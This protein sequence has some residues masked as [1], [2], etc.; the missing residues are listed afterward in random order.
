MANAPARTTIYSTDRQQRQYGR[1]T[2]HLL[3]QSGRLENSKWYKISTRN[4]GAI[5]AAWATT[6]PRQAR[7]PFTERYTSFGR[8]IAL[9]LCKIRKNRHSWD[10]ACPI[11]AFPAAAPNQSYPS[12][13]KTSLGNVGGPVREIK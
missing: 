4:R 6:Y 7:T 3:R 2:V 13:Y 12:T 1:R 10:S 8:V 11:R 5:S 9:I